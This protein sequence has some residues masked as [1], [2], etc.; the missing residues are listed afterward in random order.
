MTTWPTHHRSPTT[1]REMAAP[2]RRRGNDPRVQGCFAAPFGFATA[3]AMAAAMSALHG[4]VPPAADLTAMGLLVASV[5]WLGTWPAPMAT[6]G[7]TWLLLNGFVADRYGELR[8][9][10]R[11]DVVRIVV[12]LAI[13]AVVALLREAQ[14]RHGGRAR[15]QL[16]D[17]ELPGLAAGMSAERHA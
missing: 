12:L 9:H 13:G 16:T 7:C 15:A 14:V 8:W 10:G 17:L 11:D 4:H 3:F 2:L 6:A 5:G 1:Y